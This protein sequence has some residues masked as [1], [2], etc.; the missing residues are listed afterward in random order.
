MRRR[1]ALV[2]AVAALAGASCASGARRVAAGTALSDAV[3]DA[4]D[5]DV[6]EVESGTHVGQTAVITQAQLTLRGVGARPVLQGAGQSAEG[7]ALIVVRGGDVRIE[8]LEMRGARVASGNGAGIR[9]ESGRLQVQRCAFIDNE[10]GLLTAN[11]TDIELTVRDCEFAEAPRHIGLLHHLLYVGRIG[12]FEI[13]GSRLHGGF[14]G[15]LIKSRAQ[16]NH[17]HAN[18]VV[19]DDTGESSYELDL[20]NGGLAWVVGNVF[21]QAA[22]TQNPALVAFGAE[23]DPHVDSL[24]VMAHNTLVN[25]AD[26]DQAEF[27]KVWRDRLPP[28]AEVRLLN[29]LVAGPGRFDEAAWAGSTGNLRVGTP[30]AGDT[31]TRSTYAIVGDHRAPA[32]SV[33]GVSLTPT[34]EFRFPVGARPLPPR[35]HWQPGAFQ[36]D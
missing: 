12:R 14:R 36:D 34:E 26:S 9:L 4:R 22:R 2:G 28:S 3:R 24:L 31:H 6:I 35:S 17:I 33:R 29:N 7:K 11:R 30:P 18:F 1:S 21:G 32:A 16:L 13:S 8:N 23:A 20:P 15:H 27:V 10:M 5:G 25:R 19:D